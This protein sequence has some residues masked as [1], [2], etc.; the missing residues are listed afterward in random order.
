M[1]DEITLCRFA[2][3]GST[4]PETLNPDVDGKF[5]FAPFDPSGERLEI[6]GPVK[7]SV[8]V[9]GIR[10]DLP[11]VNREEYMNLVAGA[12]EHIREKN[13]SKV[14]VARNKVIDRPA[15]FDPEAFFKRLCS[16]YT[17]AFRYMLFHPSIGFWIG[18]SPELL[19]SH[20][21]DD[22][23]T[24]A[25]AGTLT[26]NEKGWTAKEYDEQGIVTRFIAEELTNAGAQDLHIGKPETVVA[27]NVSHLKTDI[28]GS[29]GSASPEVLLK[30]LH[31]TPAVAGYPRQASLDFIR[32][33]ESLQRDYYAGYFGLVNTDRSLIH[34]NLRCMRLYD[35]KIEFFAGAGIT[36]DSDPLKEWVET[37]RKIDTL[38][39]LI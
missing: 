6:N 23:S 20:A 28:S 37:E 8:Q 14:V 26:G 39:S 30:V 4:D 24:V 7:D 5:V 3:P 32:D 11:V 22:F 1:S 12:V 25:L 34:V 19:L 18:A 15:D 29:I 21:G 9:T 33:H 36:V 16:E 27:A 38:L 2:R 31:P 10:P 13:L 17:H 35:D